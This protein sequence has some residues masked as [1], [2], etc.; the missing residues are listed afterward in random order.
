MTAFPLDAVRRQLAEAG[1][2]STSVDIE[3]MPDTGLAHWHARIVGRGLVVRAP[4]Q[5]QMRLGAAE[6]LAYQAACFGAAQPSGAT[7]NLF[8]VLPP[9]PDLP[10]GALIV[11]EIVGRP[12][13]LPADL[14]AIAQA[15]AA[16]HGCPETRHRETLLRPSQPFKAMLEE[17]ETQA[18]YL[19]AAGLPAAVATAIETERACARDGVAANPSPQTALISFDA[20]PGNFLIR[21]DG[22]AVLVDLEKARISLPGFDLAHASLYTSTT[23]D[24]AVFAVLEPDEVT[25]FYRDWARTLGR[26]AGRFQSA[27]LLS[28]RLMWLW[29]VTWCAKWRCTSGKAQRHGGDLASNAE[30]WS[31]EKSESSLIDHVRNRVDDYL[32]APVVDRIRAEFSKLVF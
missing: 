22:T 11:E 16:I 29:S 20:H 9:R 2:F 25:A 32:S 7:P 31:A 4:K 3:P 6:N 13:R 26:S 1:G 21:D 8:G 14:P 19:A 10:L 12:P 28:R 5:S 24:P 15:L 18:R 23:W 17:V 30:D 27:H